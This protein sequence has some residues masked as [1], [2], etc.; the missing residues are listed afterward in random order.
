[1][2]IAPFFTWPQFAQPGATGLGTQ[3]LNVDVYT[4]GLAV[5]G[6]FFF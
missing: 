1:M 3:K 5:R 6:F 2:E 4:A